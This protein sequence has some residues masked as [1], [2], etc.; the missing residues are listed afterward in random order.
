MFA[1]KNS[2][3]FKYPV[4][5]IIISMDKNEKRFSKYVGIPLANRFH[6]PL[7]ASKVNL[8]IGLFPIFKIC[9]IEWIIMQFVVA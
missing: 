4:I 6:Q 9:T 3:S 7:N 8:R 1:T 2:G 5:K